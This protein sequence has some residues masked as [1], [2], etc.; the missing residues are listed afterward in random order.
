M[1]EA[2]GISLK[3]TGRGWKLTQNFRLK[4]KLFTS[5]LFSYRVSMSH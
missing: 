2:V 5:E 4:P 3:V 1:F